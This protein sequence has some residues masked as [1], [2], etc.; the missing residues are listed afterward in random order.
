MGTEQGLAGEE[1]SMDTKGKWTKECID[2]DGRFKK[3]IIRDEDRNNVCDIFYVNEKGEAHADRILDSVNSHASLVAERDA[4]KEALTKIAKTCCG[5]EICGRSVQDLKN[6][7]R[8]AL[9]GDHLPKGT[10]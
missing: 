1:L 10:P 2:T 7:A 9:D 3:W 8:L 4:M 5:G 6:I